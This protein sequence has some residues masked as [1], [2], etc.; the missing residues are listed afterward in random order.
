MILK[1]L[2]K[3]VHP[4][5][6][7]L[8]HGRKQAH[9]NYYRDAYQ[10]IELYYF[11][12]V[13]ELF[14]FHNTQYISVFQTKIH[15]YP[16]YKVQTKVPYLKFSHL[17]LMRIAHF[18]FAFNFKRSPYEKLTETSLDW[19]EFFSII[20]SY[21]TISNH[22]MNPPRIL[23]RLSSFSFSHNWKISDAEAR[24]DQIQWAQCQESM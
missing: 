12:T 24:P 1:I 11:Q 6:K 8:L 7:K 17:A 10:T 18:V 9:P 22:L 19:A 23:D 2:E 5:I 3:L 14:Q 16:N 21:E 4:Y 13:L 20:G 15:R